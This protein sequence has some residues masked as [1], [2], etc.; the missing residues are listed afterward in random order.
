MD[1]LLADEIHKFRLTLDYDCFF[2]TLIVDKVHL[3]FMYALQVSI[4]D[5]CIPTTLLTEQNNIST[6]VNNL[7]LDLDQALTHAAES[8]ERKKIIYTHLPPPLDYQMTNKCHNIQHISIEPQTVLLCQIHFNVQSAI[9][10][11]ILS[12]IPDKEIDKS[13]KPQSDSNDV[14]KVISS[15]I[16]DKERDTSI[17]TQS[18][19]NDVSKVI[20]SHI[21]NKESKLKDK[22]DICKFLWKFGLY[23]FILNKQFYNNNN[24]IHE[25]CQRYRNLPIS[26]D[27]NMNVDRYRDPP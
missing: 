21:S 17:K 10:R 15:Q 19:S 18:Y 8:L 6:T 16:P 2:L 3:D 22:L 7:K 9:P 27:L 1:S 12:H 20:S 5:Q 4:N 25:N 13:L 26:I 23:N 14:S 24:E 11:I